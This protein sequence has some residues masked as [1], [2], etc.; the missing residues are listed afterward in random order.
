VRITS[1]E[2]RGI[3]NFRGNSIGGVA[4]NKGTTFRLLG[5]GGSFS[6]KKLQETVS[7]G[8]AGGGEGAS[9]PR[10]VD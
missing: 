10:G 6:V 2:E 9:C 1:G 8:W 7:T 4:E 5:G 3:I